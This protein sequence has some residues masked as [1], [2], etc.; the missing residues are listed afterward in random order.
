M[1]IT[2]GH[3]EG[4]PVLKRAVSAFRGDDISRDESLRWLWLACHI[5]WFL[6]DDESA[7]A[8]NTRHLELSRDTGALTVLLLAL[9]QRI[10]MHEHV[11]ELAAAASLVEEAR[12]ISGL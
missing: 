3:A 8:L 5:A 6:W 2:E 12:A 9:N 7:E 1:L 4:V 10:G 11:G